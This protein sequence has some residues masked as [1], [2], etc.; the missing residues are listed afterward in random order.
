MSFPAFLLSSSSIFFLHLI[1]HGFGF[2]HH[3]SVP[4]SPNSSLSGVHPFPS[5][6]HFPSYTI[7]NQHQPSAFAPHISFS[8]S[9]A[10]SA[11]AF[12]SL[13]MKKRT[14]KMTSKLQRKIRAVS[15]TAACAAVEGAL[16]AIL[17]V[18][19]EKSKEVSLRKVQ[20]VVC[21]CLVIC[22]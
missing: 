17:F 9:S 22:G 1:S 8:S 18:R 7:K 3:A 16:D 10:V 13:C 12:A 5:C 2:E 20:C 19:K 15:E 21:F 6:K 4:Y 11:Y 14:Y